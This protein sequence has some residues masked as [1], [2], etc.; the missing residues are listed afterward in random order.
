[1]GEA[2]LYEERILPLREPAEYVGRLEKEKTFG[3]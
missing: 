3:G 1:M 2:V